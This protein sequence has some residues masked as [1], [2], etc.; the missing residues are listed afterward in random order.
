MGVYF[1]VRTLYRQRAIQKNRIILHTFVNVNLKEQYEST[2][3][4][5]ALYYVIEFSVVVVFL[6]YIYVHDF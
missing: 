3:S 4:M 2:E 6:L 1:Q 5:Y